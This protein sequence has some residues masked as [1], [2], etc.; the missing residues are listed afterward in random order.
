MQ[1]KFSLFSLALLA[2]VLATS[3]AIAN[4][5]IPLRVVNDSNHDIKVMLDHADGSSQAK[6]IAGNGDWASIQPNTDSY[7][8]SVCWVAHD[9]SNHCKC[10]TEVCAALSPTFI[11]ATGKL[12]ICRLGGLKI[13]CEKDKK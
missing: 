4:H 7:H 8:A 13:D 11:M 2:S 5:S 1:N 9:R 3:T 6:I 12:D 10:S